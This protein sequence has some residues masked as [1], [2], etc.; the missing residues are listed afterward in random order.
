[1]AN[2]GAVC[3]WQG[4]VGAGPVSGDERGGAGEVLDT[5]VGGVLLFGRGTGADA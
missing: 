2:R 4:A 1:M 5:G 3:R